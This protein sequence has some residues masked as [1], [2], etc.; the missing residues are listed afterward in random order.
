MSVE[1]RELV[2]RVQARLARERGPGDAFGAGDPAH[3]AETVR[4]EAGVISDLD[5]L[6]V[7]RALRDEATGLGPLEPVLALRG[8]T[9]VLVN[10]PEKVWFDR[11]AGLERAGVRFTDDAEVRRLAARLAVASGGRL[12]DAQPFADGRLRRDDGTVVRVHAVL[13]PPSETGTLISLRVL[14]QANLDLDGLVAAGTVS[15]VTAGRL[16]GLVAA[17]RSLL[18]VGGTGSGK[19]TLLSALLGEVGAGERVICIEDTAELRPRHPHV[20]SMSARRANVEGSGEIT[21]T[22]LVRQALR[23]RPDRIVVGEIR[24]AEIVDMLAAMNTGHDGGAGTLHANSLGEV[25]ARVEALAAMGGL[26]RV[27]AHS[28]L[29]AAVTAVLVMRR[30]ADG[31]RRLAQIGVAR[32]RADAAVEFVPA[33]DLDR[34]GADAPELV[35]TG[36]VAAPAGPAGPAAPGLDRGR[37]RGRGEP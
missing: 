32:T 25:P 8:V 7:L 4:E 10:G 3:V 34:D 9:D 35:G 27:A 29:A 17:R 1:R 2:E 21:L 19:T 16:R 36:S 37:H 18:I 20:V 14:R 5:L 33:W 15:A 23:M 28:Q 13:A 24:G 6:E 26:D 11:G 31:V 30:G 12:D 22:D